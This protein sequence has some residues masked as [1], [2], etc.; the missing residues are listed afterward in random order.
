MITISIVVCS[1]FQKLDDI[2]LQNI[3]GNI[4]VNYEVIPMYNQDSISAAYNTGIRMSRGEFICF[5]HEDIKIHTSNWGK[6]LEELFYENPSIGL[7]GIAGSTVKTKTPS[8]WW[9]CDKDKKAINIIQHFP[10]KKKEH[11]I[12]GFHEDLV[13]PA[14]SI[15]G[16][17]MALRRK[18]GAEFSPEIKGFHGYDLSLSFEVLSRNHGI[19]ITRSILLE[20]YSYGMQ[21]AEWLEAII[22]VHQHHKKV[23]PLHANNS[24]EVKNCRL[25]MDK[26]LSNKKMEWF[27]H[28]WLRLLKLKPI[29]KLHLSYLRKAIKK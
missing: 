4:G 1:R 25:L 12:I 3:T 23:F 21:N 20:H 13:S 27:Y 8:G 5:L 22:K 17:F 28:Y 24:L 10:D 6:I 26:C 7:V 29:S 19:G 11:Q 9:D 2:F 14:V 18:V 16:V 15:D